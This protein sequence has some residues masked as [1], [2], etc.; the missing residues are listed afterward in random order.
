MGKALEK[1]KN[2]M[3]T[4]KEKREAELV[5]IDSVIA[6]LQEKME[7]A[8]THEKLAT[9]SCNVA[10][11]KS[12]IAEQEDIKLQI[13]MYEKRKKALKSGQLVTEADYKTFVKEVREDLQKASR[14]YAAELTGHYEAISRI[15]AELHGLIDESNETLRILQKDFFRNADRGGI[16]PRTNDYEKPAISATRYAEMRMADE[17]A[18]HGEQLKN[19]YA[20]QYEE[21]TFDSKELPP[22]LAYMHG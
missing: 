21:N 16:D 20:H 3:Q 2:T 5:D 9:A 8:S 1:T 19:S 18:K 12:A 17:A 11:Y 4:I 10:E 15:G 22:A 7:E 13:E 14:N 6:G